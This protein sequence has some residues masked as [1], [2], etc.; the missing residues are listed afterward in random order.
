MAG[1]MVKTEPRP[2]SSWLRPRNVFQEME[3]MLSH[4]VGTEP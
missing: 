1:T 2:K 3:E 4:V